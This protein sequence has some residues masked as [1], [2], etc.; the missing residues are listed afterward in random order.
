MNFFTVLAAFVVGIGLPIQIAMNSGIRNALGHPLWGA[1]AN[2]AVG[3]VALVV[4]GVLMR[5]PIPSAAAVA[6]PS[7]WSWL[8][9]F[10]GAIYVVGSILL[11]PK[12]GATTYFA[13]IICGQL[14]ASMVLDQFGL[15]GYPLQPISLLRFIGV[16]MLIA[17]AVLVVRN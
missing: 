3:L 2:F 12:L 15:L 8:G 11:G 17:G 7:L 6:T 14:C 5:I 10:L 9:G 1:L 4:V 16:L 13:L